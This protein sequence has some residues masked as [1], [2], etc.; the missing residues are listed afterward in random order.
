MT[1]YTL[2]A[3]GLHKEVGVGS[4][5][6]SQKRREAV[7]TRLSRTQT[8]RQL[9]VVFRRRLILEFVCS[10]YR[11]ESRTVGLDAVEALEGKRDDCVF[12][13]STHRRSALAGLF[14]RR[15]D[16]PASL[17]PRSA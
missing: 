12:R 4:L 9:L 7:V 2:H 6:K 17:P 11:R 8:A 3:N 1:G 15:N 10:C 5:V 16:P 13:E 14:S